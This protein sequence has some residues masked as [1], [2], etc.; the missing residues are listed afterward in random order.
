MCFASKTI[1][2][3]LQEVENFKSKYFQQLS[4]IDKELSEYYHDLEGKKFNAA[5][6]YYIAKGLQSILHKRRKIKFELNQLHSLIYH[7][8]E[9]KK[10]L[11]DK[12]KQYFKKAPNYKEYIYN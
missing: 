11:G 8:T 4:Q 10:H 1:D 6:G 2:T 5:E 7:L 9:T 3:Q 12:E